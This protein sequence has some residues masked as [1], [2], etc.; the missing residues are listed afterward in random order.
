MIENFQNWKSTEKNKYLDHFSAE[1][2]KKLSATER[3]QHSV[4]SCQGC[5]L[6]HF[7]FQTLFPLKSNYL[8]S[9]N[10]PLQE[11][12][13]VS[14]FSPMFKTVHCK[15]PVKVTKQSLQ[16]AATLLYRSIEK[17]F[18]EIFNTSFR[19]ALLEVKE[20]QLQLKPSK[21]ECKKA[22][23]LSRRK[24]K[25]NIEMQWASNDLDVMLGTRQSF[26]QWE[27]ERKAMFFE[28]KEEAVQRVEKRKRDELEGLV[29][30]KRHSPDP[31]KV[32][33]D[34]SGLLNEVKNLKEGDQVNSLKK[35][36]FLLMYLIFP[37]MH[38]MLNE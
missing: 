15:S 18:S 8:K 5:Q 4:S 10:K 19:D 17:P 30:K 9:K 12:R 32:H 38:L 35:L 26:S 2:W 22:I 1:N 6:H 29:K 31:S 37:P 28:S 33:F 36:L 20:L 25:K 23:R 24:E 34:K 27:R 16:S 14:N 13:N 11:L 21:S 3:K 7:H